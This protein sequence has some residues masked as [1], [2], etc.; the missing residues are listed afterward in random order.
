MVCEGASLAARMGFRGTAAAA[1][2][3]APQFLHER[4]TDTEALCNRRLGR[5][6]S[7][8][9]VD[10]PVTK[11]LGVCFHTPKYAPN[12]PDRQLQPALRLLGGRYDTV[13]QEQDAR[14][15]IA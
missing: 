13:L 5:F 3:P 9:R 7:L 10:N 14:A 8:H 2:K 15:S 11:I 4:E 1:A 6:T 12:V